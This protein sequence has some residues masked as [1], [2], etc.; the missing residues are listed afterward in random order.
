MTREAL[1]GL[2]PTAGGRAGG[3]VSHC[4]RKSRRYRLGELDEAAGRTGRGLGLVS[5]GPCWLR[6]DGLPCPLQP[7]QSRRSVSDEETSQEPPRAPGGREGCFR[8]LRL[9]LRLEPEGQSVTP[10]APAWALP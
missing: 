6:K 4:G 3:L 10:E 8:R 7:K 5:A 1:P 2:A 9:G